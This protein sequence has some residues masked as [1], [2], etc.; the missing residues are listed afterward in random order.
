MW[1]ISAFLADDFITRISQQ[2]LYQG[3]FK[4]ILVVAL[5]E[6]SQIN[7]TDVNTQPHAQECC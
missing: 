5:I 2:L 6:A 4:H 3:Y 7:N 1:V